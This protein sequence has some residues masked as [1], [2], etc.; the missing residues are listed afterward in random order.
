MQTSF[1]L[2]LKNYG[3]AAFSVEC[4]IT[5]YFLHRQNGPRDY[6]IIDKYE[7]NYKPTGPHQCDKIG[8]TYTAFRNQQPAGCQQKR[9]AWVRL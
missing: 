1:W 8:V 2:S 4:L 3:R 7:V 6:L 5:V 9:G